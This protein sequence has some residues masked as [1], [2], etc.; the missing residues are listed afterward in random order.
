MAEH[1][2]DFE[3]A[4]QELEEQAAQRKG[5]Q[6]QMVILGGGVGRRRK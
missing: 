5:R 1:S 6:R 4:W 2:G 3:V